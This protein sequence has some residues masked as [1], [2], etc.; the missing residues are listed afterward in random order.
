M[1][2]LRPNCECCDTDLPPDSQEAYICSYE[3]TF[4]KSCVD[5]I[6]SNVCPNCGGG[7]SKRPIRP[8]HEHRKGVSVHIQQPSNNRVHTK[9]TTNQMKAFSHEIKNISENER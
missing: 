9:Y 7:F 5:E 1:L 4:C 2:E 6:L 3:C 8:K